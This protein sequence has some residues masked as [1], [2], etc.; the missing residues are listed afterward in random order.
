MEGGSGSAAGFGGAGAGG[1]VVVPRRGAGIVDGTRPF[2]CGASLPPV[3]VMSSR[4]DV[5]ASSLRMTDIS[6]LLAIPFGSVGILIS[7][8]ALPQLH[9]LCRRSIKK[10]MG[11]LP[12]D[13]GRQ[14]MHIARCHLGWDSL[15]D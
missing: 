15:E 5:A 7:H 11:I 10:R 14:I 6:A 1:A 12:L 4:R 8:K 3:D 2:D 9:R 13:Q